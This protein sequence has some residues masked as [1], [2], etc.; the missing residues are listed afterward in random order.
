M[1]K[2]AMNKKS[3]LFPSIYGKI[4]GGNGINFLGA[5]EFQ[6]TQKQRLIANAMLFIPNDANLSRKT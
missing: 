5:G 3:T 1:P 6:L 2:N 4:W